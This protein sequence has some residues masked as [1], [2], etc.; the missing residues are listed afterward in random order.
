MVLTA[1]AVV[2]LQLG[3]D[4]MKAGTMNHTMKW[5]MRAM[6]IIMLPLISNFPSVSQWVYS[7]HSV[8]LSVLCV[9]VCFLCVLSVSVYSC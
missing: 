4:G 6:P 1:V 8:F 9:C 7:G 2:V 3:V 5:F